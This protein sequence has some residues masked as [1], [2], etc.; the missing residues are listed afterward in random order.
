MRLILYRTLASIVIAMVLLQW[1]Y[2]ASELAQQQLIVATSMLFILLLLIQIRLTYTGVSEK[3]LWVFQYA[4]DTIIASILVFASGG[5]FSPFSFLYGLIIIASGTHA[6]RLLPVAVSILACSGYLSSVYGEAWLARTEGLS[7]QQALHILLQVSALMLVGGVMAYIARRHASLRARSDR[8]VRQHRK[9]KDLHD[10][11]MAEMAEGVIVLDRELH[12]SDMNPAARLLLG[13]K[14]V[15]SLLRVPAI[16]AFFQQ[17]NASTC[18][19]EFDDAGGKTKRTLLLAVRQLSADVDAMWLLTL[20]DISE[21]R[22]LEQQLVQQEKMAV[23]GKMAAMLA[24]EIRNPIQTMGQ[25]LELMSAKPECSDTL[26]EILRD[27][28]LRLNRL[29]GMMLDYARPLT[30][31]PV[32][33]Y[34]PEVF[35]QALMHVAFEGRDQVSGQCRIDELKVDSDHF[36]LVLDNL[37]SNAVANQISGSTVDV[38]LDADGQEWVLMVSNDGELAEEV[39]NT[40]FEPFVTGRSSGIGL[41]LAT[42]RQLCVTNGW[43]VKVDAEAGRVCFQVRGLLEPEVERMPVQTI[44]MQPVEAPSV[45]DSDQ[46]DADQS[47]EDQSVEDQSA[48]AQAAGK[49]SVR[50][51]DG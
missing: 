6:L 5:V 9:L 32:L 28:T 50:V 22:R 19:C 51:N 1:I 8:A 18:Q 43:T 39:R 3:K 12:I 23:L 16:D 49:K 2:P 10:Q 38:M 37:L 4:T 46:S 20:V 27:E 42:V 15:A 30:P 24:H 11:I 48:E 13:E 17:S 35:R 47:V 40:L 44:E 7:T 29:V 36:R 41:G 25:G 14:S 26:R 31:N 34:M 45:A 21:V 33:T